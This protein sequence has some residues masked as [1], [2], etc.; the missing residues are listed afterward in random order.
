MEKNH[1]NK[2]KN[3]LPT[4]EEI[5]SEKLF[6]LDTQTRHAKELERLGLTEKARQ[7]F[8]AEALNDLSRATLALSRKKEDDGTITETVS[9]RFATAGISTSGHNTTSYKYALVVEVTDDSMALAGEFTLQEAELVINMIAGL[10][11]AK[12]LGVLPHLSADLASIEDPNTAMMA[13]RSKSHKG[14]SA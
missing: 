7:S 3:R 11:D 5:E 4:P 10:K 1:N 14:Y 13:T 2:K 9:I 8:E 12:N 6:L